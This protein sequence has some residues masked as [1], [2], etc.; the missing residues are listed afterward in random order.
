MKSR[1]KWCYGALVLINLLI[2]MVYYTEI[3]PIVVFDT[4]DWLYLY[5]M[6]SFFPMWKAWNPT[7]V[8]PEVLMPL[9]TRFGVYLIMPFL[10][11]ETAA[12][13]LDAVLI[14]HSLLISLIWVFYFHTIYLFINRVSGTP[15]AAENLAV[16]EMVVLAHFVPLSLNNMAHTCL[17]NEAD[18]T[19]VF[20]YTV[21]FLFNGAFLFYSLSVH[22]DYGFQN[23]R[24]RY[25]KMGMVLLWAY[26]CVNSNMWQSIL[27]A[28]YSFA[29]L[30]MRFVHRS[31]ETKIGTFLKQN[32]V[33]I[34]VLVL[35]AI[36]LF[37][38]YNGGRASITGG[39]FASGKRDTLRTFVTVSLPVHSRLVLLPVLILIAGEV[40]RHKKKTAGG[41][42]EK[43]ALFSWLITNVFLVLLALKL[44][45]DYLARPSVIYVSNFW[46][47]CLVIYDLTTVIRNIA[48]TKVL[49]PFAIVCLFLT[50]YSNS[51]TYERNTMNRYSAKMDRAITCDIIGQILE[52][53]ENSEKEV[54]LYVPKFD[55]VDNWPIAGYGASRYPHTL[56][57]YGLIKNNMDAAII[58]TEEKNR[59]FGLEVEEFEP[60]EK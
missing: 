47:L 50:F 10:R 35:Y 40:I 60:E 21:A 22:N 46:I 37:Y 7:K 44:G 27:I 59:Q 54:V 55:S 34:T 9:S 6:H 25:F 45:A 49:V 5:A 56:Y 36:M 32:Y 24:F 2:L 39:G 4:D 3:N 18:V 57:Y 14:A 17:L 13:F 43:V 52:A 26:L 58:P 8:L 53:D 41:S 33:F 11:G 15:Q 38:E 29:V 16:Y 23:S 19:C 28:S 12:R 20:N 42:M 30:L 51:G 48:Q 31:K 1:R